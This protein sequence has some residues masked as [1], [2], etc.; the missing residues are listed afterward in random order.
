MIFN[1]TYFL[2]VDAIFLD[3]NPE[4]GEIFMRFIVLP[5]KKY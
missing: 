4:A 3:I 1:P 2:L 5:V